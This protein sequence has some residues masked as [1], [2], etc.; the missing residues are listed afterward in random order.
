MATARDGTRYVCAGPEDIDRALRVAGPF[1]TLALRPLGAAELGLILGA[2]GVLLCPGAFAPAVLAQVAA[3]PGRVRAAVLLGDGRSRRLMA[4]DARL[5]DLR[6]IG[7]GAAAARLAA[8]HPAAR[9]L[10]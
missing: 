2:R 1:A 3:D 7:G 4:Q 9:C 10:S 5:L 6:L 8:G